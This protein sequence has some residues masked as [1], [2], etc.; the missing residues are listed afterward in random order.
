MS[1]DAVVKI[2]TQEMA[3]FAAT[4]LVSAILHIIIIF[5]SFLISQIHSVNATANDYCERKLMQDIQA[6]FVDA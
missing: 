3:T 6:Y 4:T 2:S 5:T 1:F